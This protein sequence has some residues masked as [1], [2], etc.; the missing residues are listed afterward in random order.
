MPAPRVA[1]LLLALLLAPSAAVAE[2]GAFVDLTGATV[3]ASPG[4]PA[5]LFPFLP[6]GRA[7][8]P[9]AWPLP[10]GPLLVLGLPGADEAARQVA[11]FW[12]LLD[13]G[14]DLHGGYLVAAWHDGTRPIAVI[15]ADDA[16]ALYAARF[17]LESAP[18]RAPASTVDV[19]R[20]PE[21]AGVCV[22]LGRQVVRP[23]F[24]VRALYP[25]SPGEASILDAVAGRANRY[26]IDTRGGEGNLRLLPLLRRHGIVPVAVV[27]AD[28]R[29]APSIADSLRPWIERGGVRHVVLDPIGSDAA[30]RRDLEVLRESFDLDE[31]V[32]FHEKVRVPGTVATWPAPLG[33]PNWEGLGKVRAEEVLDARA[34]TP[35]DLLFVETWAQATW[36]PVPSRPRGRPEEV[37]RLFDGVVVMGGLLRTGDVEVLEDAWSREAGGREEWEDVLLPVLPRRPL[38]PI[39]F[40]KESASR[41]EEADRESR[42]AVPWLQRVSRGALGAARGLEAARHAL[43]VPRVPQT[44]RADGSLD[45]PAWAHAAVLRFRLVGEPVGP[46]VT[47]LAFADGRQLHIAVRGPPDLEG[48]HL[49]IAATSPVGTGVRGVAFGGPDVA[50]AEGAS[51]VQHDGRW[52][53]RRGVDAFTWEGSLDHFE[54]WGDAHPLRT[55]E[56]WEHMGQQESRFVAPLVLGP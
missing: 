8:A 25:Q 53:W 40:L 19:T 47:L 2:E 22:H 3:V 18:A 10:D 38:D 14:E 11:F 54:L 30:L 1:L 56:V 20:P 52:A 24:R 46:E 55:F 51:G 21:E 49:G 45:E 23:R 36:T 48:V 29:R 5:G 28:G 32:L 12:D 39:A 31:I 17:E 16:A 37:A 7:P 13:P 34:S 15:L 44:I 50:H 35:G 33:M 6:G 27:R 26:W 42:H 9:L 43:L 41:I 4:T